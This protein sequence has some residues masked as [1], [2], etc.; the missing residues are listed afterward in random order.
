MSSKKYNKELKKNSGFFFNN[1]GAALKLHE[2]GIK[3]SFLEYLK[4]HKI[5]SKRKIKF[6]LR[7]YPVYELTIP[8]IGSEI[9]KNRLINEFL[10]RKDKFMQLSMTVAISYKC[11]QI[12]NQCYITEYRNFSR[13]EMTVDEFKI[14]FDKIVNEVKVWHFDIT[15]GE[16]FEHPR[17]FEIIKQIPADKAT[18]IVATNG[19][20]IDEKMISKIKCSNIMACKVS[21]DLYSGLNSYSMRKALNSIKMLT[22][23]KVYTFAQV[24]LERGF[25]E[26]FDI[27]VIIEKCRKAGA[28]FINFI[29][30]M[31]IGNLRGRDDLFL[32]YEERKNI[33]FWQRYYSLKYEYQILLF[34]DWEIID[35][36]CLAARDRI[37]IDPYGDIHP[38]NF[39]PRPYGNI[40]TDNLRQVISNMQNDIGDRPNCCYSTNSSLNTIKKIYMQIF[41]SRIH[42]RRFSTH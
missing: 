15:G 19:F 9:C 3:K 31:A 21:L 24:Y 26:Y 35:T 30:P 6:E 41:G 13:K 34:P 27:R 33:Y 40:L 16:P 36:G 8:P 22:G 10:Y 28:E 2:N 38:C 25:G 7:G 20:L 4:S 23:N 39:I 32:T 14:A 42:N 11:S 5:I 18:A 12:C 29:S 37:Y 1:Y 17:F